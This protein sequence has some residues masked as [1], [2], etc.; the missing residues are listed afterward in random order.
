MG[1]VSDADEKRLLEA[2]ARA[3]DKIADEHR[4]ACGTAQLMRAVSSAARNAAAGASKGPSQ[5]ATPAYR[6]NWDTL[7]GKKQP[8]GQA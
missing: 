5:V 4:P 3:A 7:F 6:E 8:V 1:R 2:A